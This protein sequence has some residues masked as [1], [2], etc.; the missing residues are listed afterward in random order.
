ML[1]GAHGRRVFLVPQSTGTQRSIHGVVEDNAKKEA[2]VNQFDM[3]IEDYE[4]WVA[5]N[6]SI[7]VPGSSTTNSVCVPV[8][9]EDSGLFG[10]L[11]N[12][13]TVFVDGWEESLAGNDVDIPIL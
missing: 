12:D 10:G 11:Y 7:P 13:E 2:V 5:S 6:V 4:D 8:L 1:V 9:H 3:T